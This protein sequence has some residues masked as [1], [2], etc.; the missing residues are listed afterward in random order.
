MTATAARGDAL[1]VA[2][3]AVWLRSVM[4]PRL[5][6][7]NEAISIRKDGP[8]DVD[9]LRAA[10]NAL[11]A[12]YDA[13]H[14]VFIRVKGTP[15]RRIVDPPHF[16]LPL[17]DLSRLHRDEAERRATRVVAD[18]AQIPYDIR[19]GPLVRPRLIRFAPDHHRLYLAMHH[20]AF[21]GVSL[22]RTVLRDLVA[23][24]DLCRGAD[25][26]PLEVPVRYSDYALYEQSWIEGPRAQRRLEHWREHLQGLPRPSLPIDHARPTT[27]Q[28]HGA[29]VAVSIDASTTTR[30]HEVART[31]RATLFQVLA[32]T[33]AAVL[34]R[35]MAHD[36]V[37]FATPADV[38]QR[39]AFQ[40]LVGYCI[41]PLVLRVDVSGEPTFSDLVAQVRDGVLDGLDNLVPFER[42]VRELQ[43]PQ[44]SANPVFQTLL[45]LEPAT[46]SS[47]REWSLHQIDAPLADAI[48]TNKVD[49]ELQ[50]D[51]R[52][53]GALHGRL[54]YDQDLFDRSSVA[55]LADRWTRLVEQA[56]AAPQTSVARLPLL[57]SEEERRELVEFNATAATPSGSREV[58]NDAAQL[59]AAAAETLQLGPADVLLVFGHSLDPA[60]P[61]A[62]M[63][64]HV[65]ARIVVAPAGLAADGLAVNRMVAAQSVTVLVATPP[66]WRSLLGSGLRTS[67][68][69]AALCTTADEWLGPDL[70]A[71][72]LRR[73]R[74]LWSAYGDAR[75]GGYCLLGRVRS[76]RDLALGRPLDNVRAYVLDRRDQLVPVGVQGELVIAGTGVNGA[77]QAGVLEPGVCI[78][79]L[80]GSGPALRTGDSARRLADGRLA[81]PVAG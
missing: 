11:V 13:W 24:Y 27:P 36:D 65:G 66:Q 74:V 67:R 76:D 14:T 4:S 6:P 12:R 59:A 35:H 46:M 54:I 60:S 15:A 53:D 2:Q 69:L 16:A 64:E 68:T 3:E 81:F 30:L 25:V 50:L 43:I 38:R 80:F 47:D 62:M 17:L 63:A 49:L 5:I 9:A 31:H 56:S 41:T 7:Y 52:Q 40:G 20:I 51:E 45:V 77:L 19:R 28:A 70:A 18:L 61:P 26:E 39:P 1:S 37:V 22:T 75:T 34:A 33:W 8:L 73:C 57:S 55:G 10:V 23:L 79:D 78:A 44:A 58:H 21:D 29:T 72:I 42:I 48:G 32:A 71:D